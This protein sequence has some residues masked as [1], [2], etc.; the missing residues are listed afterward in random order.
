MLCLYQYSSVTQAAPQRPPE[1]F[2]LD[3]R[4][5]GAQT[6]P[7]SHDSG[8]TRHGAASPL[9]LQRRRAFCTSKLFLGE[10]AAVVV[11]DAV[12]TL[13]VAV[14]PHLGLAALF[15]TEA[16]GPALRVAHH[17][18][19]GARG[20]TRLGRGD[21]ALAGFAAGV[22]GAEPAL[23][24]ALLGAPD[25]PLALRDGDA[26]LRARLDLAGHELVRAH[27]VVEEATDGGAEALEVREEG[28]A[29]VPD[30]GVLLLARR[31]ILGGG[32]AGEEGQGND[33]EGADHGEA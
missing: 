5:T 3:R 30:D 9:S 25:P 19:R 2:L 26:D 24:L 28:L 29:R 6:E 27:A 21:P 23:L 22:A 12:P 10:A 31:P 33:G 8:C 7:L 11:V 13:R 32:P 4:K 14:R 1:A 20:S 17:H 16:L 18:G 15:V